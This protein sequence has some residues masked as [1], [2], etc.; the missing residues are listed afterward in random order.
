MTAT[1]KKTARGTGA[2]KKKSKAKKAT[3][4][5]TK[6]AAKK[7]VKKVAKKA[8]TK[9]AAVVETAL[10]P[11]PTITAQERDRMIAERAYHLSQRRAPG[12]GTPASD[13]FA[14]AAEIDARYDTAN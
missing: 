3:K 7:P 12:A 2:S 6:K 10:E 9:P 11:R 8:A 1:A 4:K 14:A 13:W 5:T